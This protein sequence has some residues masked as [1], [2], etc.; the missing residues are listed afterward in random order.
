[1]AVDQ[2]LVDA[3]VAQ[4][5]ERHP[6][7][8]EGGAAAVRGANGEIFTSV[9]FENINGGVT[10]CHETGGF[11]QAFTKNVAVTDSVCVARDPLF[12]AP[13]ILAPC[14]ICRERLALW[15]PDVEVGV[16]D[17]ADP[18]KCLSRRLSEVHVSYW[19][20]Q[21]PDESGWSRRES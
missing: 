18:T 19:G 21:Y 9:A 12:D 11:I 6:D 16:P 8:P 1:M 10:L 20:R 15:G 3:A 4:M 14:G 2:E 5:D 7:D 13:V 17:P